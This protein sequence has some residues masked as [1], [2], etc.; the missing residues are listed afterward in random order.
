MPYKLLYAIAYSE[1]L[2]QE[3]LEFL[4]TQKYRKF[5]TSFQY[6]NLHI[7]KKFMSKHE[8]HHHKTCLDS[9]YEILTA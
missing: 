1:F 9:E 7:K 5:L 3:N 2:L 8:I 6:R 4:C